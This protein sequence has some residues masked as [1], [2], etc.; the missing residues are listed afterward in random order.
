M[1]GTDLSLFGAIG[2][3]L[4]VP[5]MEPLRGQTAGTAAEFEV[6]SVKPAKS[7]AGVVGG[8]HGIDSRYGPSETA[9]PPLGRCVI[10]DARLGHLINMAYDLRSMS[11]IKGGPDWVTIGSDRFNIEAK[12]EAPATATEQQLLHMLQRLLG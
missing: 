6:A 12:A 10:T 2:L 1:K 7:P 4:F 5:S 9:Q 3:V 8:C 11:L